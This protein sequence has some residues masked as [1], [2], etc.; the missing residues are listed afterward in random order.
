MSHPYIRAVILAGLLAAPAPAVQADSIS[1][2]ALSSLLSEGEAPLILD[3]RSEREYE[4]GHVPGA[5]NIPY[6]EL[7]ARLSE[8][9][10]SEDQEVVVYCEVGGRAEIA[11]STL[12]DAGYTRVRMLDGHMRHWRTSDYPQE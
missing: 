7:P 5:V 11:Q 10:A 8:L 9:P 4:S 12:K 1:A 2:P 3:V 6:Q